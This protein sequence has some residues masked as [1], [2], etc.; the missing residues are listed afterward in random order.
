MKNLLITG[1]DA[2]GGENIN[3]SWESV[4]LIN[5][6]TANFNVTKLQ[7]PT[8]FG[9]ASEIVVKKAEEKILTTLNSINNKTAKSSIDVFYLTN[10]L[11]RHNYKYYEEYKNN[12]L[13]VINYEYNVNFHSQQIKK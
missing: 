12:L 11:Y 2:F 5:E 3:P 6:K 13:Q 9:K 4:K 8:V 7:I 10:K 1:F